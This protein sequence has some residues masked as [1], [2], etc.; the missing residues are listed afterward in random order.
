M[1]L[2]FGYVKAMSHHS[3]LLKLLIALREIG[4]ERLLWGRPQTDRF[5]PI[6]VIAYAANDKLIQCAR[7]SRQQSA[8]SG[9]RKRL[10]LIFP[11]DTQKS[12]TLVLQRLW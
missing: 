10:R 3:F 11:L 7:T 12:L 6:T 9:S 5:W 2:I 4:C 8:P 1:Q